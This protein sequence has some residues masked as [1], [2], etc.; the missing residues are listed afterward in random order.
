ML[1]HTV[2][3]ISSDTRVKLTSTV[4]DINVPR[5]VHIQY[6]LNHKDRAGLPSR[7]EL[8]PLR[9][10]QGKFPKRRRIN[11]QK[12]LSMTE[13]Q[14]FKRGLAGLPSLHSGQA[15]RSSRLDRKAKIEKGADVGPFSILAPRAGLPSLR[16]G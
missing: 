13:N 3:K 15:H 1:I 8:V 5:L 10:T 9:L 6:L 4:T 2:F 12:V 11:S 14:E 16:S 7:R